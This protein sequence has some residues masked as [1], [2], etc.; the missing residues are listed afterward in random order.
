[1]TTTDGLTQAERERLTSYLAETH[2]QVLRTVRGFSDR[3]LDFKSEL[4]RWSISENVEHMTIVHNL[5]QN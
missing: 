3:Q 1:M 4:D 2:D 5:V